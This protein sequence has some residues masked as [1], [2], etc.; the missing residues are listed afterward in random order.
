[1]KEMIEDK[2]R[3]KLSASES[4]TTWMIRHAAFLQTRFSVGNDGK[5]PVRRRHSLRLHEPASAIWISCCESPRRG[6]LNAANSIPDSFHAFE[7][8]RAT[9]TSSEQ[10]WVYTQ[11]GRF[12]QR[13][14]RTSGTVVSPRAWKAHRGLRGLRTVK[15]KFGR[16]KS[17]TGR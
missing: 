14:I 1:M 7:P 6:R 9:S 16:Q 13:M 17:D 10:H 3:T 8:Q 12:E 2:A 5:T 4:N 15:R 11:Q